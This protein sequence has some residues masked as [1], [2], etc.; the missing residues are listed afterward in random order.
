[1][2]PSAV[3]KPRS[4]AA[5]ETRLVDAGIRADVDPATANFMRGLCAMRTG[6]LYLLA[7]ESVAGYVGWV[8][9]GMDINARMVV[10]LP[11][12]FDRAVVQPCFDIDL[13][14]SGHVQR[15]ASFCGDVSHHKF[16]MVAVDLGD[17]DALSTLDAL[18]AM[19]N[20][21]GALIGMHGSATRS[22]IIDANED[23]AHRLPVNEW[24]I[25][26]FAAGKLW[27]AARRATPRNKRRGGRRAS[28]S[29]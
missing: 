16:S 1:M 22:R 7:G 4:A 8:L 24:I 9:D 23:L 3:D 26:Q 27:F 29:R 20:P 2:T 19:V 25:T 5:L 14:V 13:R 12:R 15:L 18:A 11:E 10:V 28:M 6:G 17:V 21:G